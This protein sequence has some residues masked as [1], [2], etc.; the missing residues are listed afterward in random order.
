M[1][2]FQFQE[3]TCTDTVLLEIGMPPV[4]HLVQKMGKSFAKK[5]LVST[6]FDKTLLHKIYKICEEKQT[7]AYKF[8]K[9]YLTLRIMVVLKY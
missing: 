7:N 4:K 9:N 1:L 6:E 5:N 3:T 8:I 2:K